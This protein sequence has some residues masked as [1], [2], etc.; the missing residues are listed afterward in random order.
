MP[1]PSYVN[2]FNTATDGSLHEQ[3]FIDW[4]HE[5]D[6]FPLKFLVEYLGVFPETKHRNDGTFDTPGLAKEFP[7]YTACVMVDPKLGVCVPAYPGL[8]GAMISG[9]CRPR[10]TFP[11]FVHGDNGTYK[12]MGTYREPRGPDRMSGSETLDIPTHVKQYW[13]GYLGDDGQGG[14]SAEQ[15]DTLRSICLSATLGWHGGG[16][17]V[18]ADGDPQASKAALAAGMKRMAGTMAPSRA[19]KITAE[20]VLEAFHR[21]S[22]NSKDSLCSH[23]NQI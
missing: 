3:E 11:L 20:E 21:V 22:D 7:I 8:H 6:G 14:K 5:N 17:F 23:A 12:Y 10:T 4:F 2:K 15:I 16:Q 9:L 19:R 18:E 1:L 13:A